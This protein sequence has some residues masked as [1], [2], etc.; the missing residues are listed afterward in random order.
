MQRQFIGAI[1]L[2]SDLE[3]INSKVREFAIVVTAILLV[4]LLL[5]F[6]LSAKLQTVISAPIARL[7]RTAEAVSSTTTSR[8]APLRHPMTI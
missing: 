8:S 7:A 2:E 1:Y 5:A 6:V 3:E 4:A